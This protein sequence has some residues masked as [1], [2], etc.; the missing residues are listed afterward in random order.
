MLPIDL[1]HTMNK[2]EVAAYEARAKA[3]AEEAAAT[4]AKVSKIHPT[5]Q[6]TY[7]PKQETNPPSNQQPTNNQP[8]IKP[9]KQNL[10]WL[11]GHHNSMRTVPIWKQV[12]AETPVLPKLDFNTVLRQRFAAEASEMR[13]PAQSW[14]DCL[15][16]RSTLMAG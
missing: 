14:S 2:E 10:Y 15:N 7:L 3:A 5:K 12:Q 1:S 8:T 9:N 11:C 6:E 4:G 16:V 13:G